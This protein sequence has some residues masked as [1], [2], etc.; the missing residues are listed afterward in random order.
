MLDPKDVDRLKSI[1]ADGRQK[2]VPALES[3]A[4]ASRTLG[5]LKAN[6]TTAL[7]ASLGNVL[8]LTGSGEVFLQKYFDA[9]WKQGHRLTEEHH[10]AGAGTGGPGRI[11]F[12]LPEQGW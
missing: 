1:L 4:Q 9:I 12:R 8:D 5:F 6:D 2:V 3:F 11:D 10:G 7:A